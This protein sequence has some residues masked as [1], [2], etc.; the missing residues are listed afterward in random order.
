MF[1]KT[2]D[3]LIHRSIPEAW[4]ESTEELSQKSPDGA[5]QFFDGSDDA[6]EKEPDAGENDFESNARDHPDD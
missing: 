6:R 1:D 5:E 3:Y 2:Q 4:V